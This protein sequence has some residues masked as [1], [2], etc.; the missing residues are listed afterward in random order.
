M[1]PPVAIRLGPAAPVPLAAST[2]AAGFP[3]PADDHAEDGLDLSRR[4]VRHPTSTF[5]VRSTGDS[6]TGRGILA[7]DYLVVDRSRTPRDDEVV[8]A[9]VDGAFTA[10]VFKT[11]AGRTTLVAA[12]PAYPP[13]PWH[14]GCEV[15]GVVTSVHRDLLPTAR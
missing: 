4:F 5:V 11:C 1:D 7:G 8:L 3:S 13:I 15:W 14:E 9:I 2:V 6:L 12:H 10:K